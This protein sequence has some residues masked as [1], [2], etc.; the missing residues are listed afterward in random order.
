MDKWRNFEYRSILKSPYEILARTKGAR[1]RPVS[2]PTDNGI[3]HHW[4]TNHTVVCTVHVLT[5]LD[6]RVHV[7][8]L[9][10]QPKVKAL[11]VR[12]IEI[13]GL[14]LP[15]LPGHDIQKV[16]KTTM[17]LL[18]RFHAE[19]PTKFMTVIFVSFQFHIAFSMPII[20]RGVGRMPS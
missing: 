15:S 9:S 6:H 8:L 2:P 7:K 13:G 12:H 19:R 14:S 20:I 11:D 4:I 1:I 18:N 17:F 16:M 3:L 10:F 5:A